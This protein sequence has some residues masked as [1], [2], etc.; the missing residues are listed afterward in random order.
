MALRNG[1]ALFGPT[2]WAAAVRTPDG[3]IRVESGRRPRARFA[4]RV[5]FMRGIVRMSEMLV[6]LP[7][8][9]R[10]L[11]EA[12]LSFENGGVAASTLFCAALATVVKRRGGFRSEVAATV[13][14]IV[15]SF[16]TLRNREL[17]RYHGAEHKTVAGYERDV[18]AAVTAKEHERCGT[19]LVAP[20]LL[21]A[22]GAAGV[23]ARAPAVAAPSGR[24]ARLARGR[25]LRIRALRLARAASR[26]RSAPARSRR[27][28]PRSSGR[29]QRPSP[30][31]PSSRSPSARL[32]RCSPRRVAERPRERAARRARAAALGD[33]RPAGREDAR[34]LL[35][36]RLL[37]LHEA[38][39]RARRL[40]PARAHAGLP[41][42]PVGARRHGRGD[43]R[44]ARVQR[45]HRRPTAP[46]SPAGT[47]SSCTRSTTATRSSRGRP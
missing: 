22:V 19:H 44:A 18:D 14:G 35:L 12:R 34:G 16:V 37:R 8:I 21:G 3:G 9:R 20:M 5:P 17:V 15:P 31:R 38:G 39:A 36:G 10:R 6:A 13:I 27:P 2:S 23:A 41:A 40:P 11:P 7:V 24:G 29:S 33:L 32:R 28:A 30:A 47:S 25:R 45:P 46:G 43:R 42:P 4:D 1:L 26:T